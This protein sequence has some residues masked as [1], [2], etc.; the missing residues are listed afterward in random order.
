M[1]QKIIGLSALALGCAMT[2]A[3]WSA[4]P[5]GALLASTCTGCHGPNGSS[6][7]PATPIISGI[8]VETFVGEMK[9]F[10]TGER[11]STI[12][13]RL[14]K[15]YTDEEINAMAEYFSKQKF[16]R[17]PQP[18]D[19][20]KVKAGKA[21]ASENCES[22]HVDAGRKDED[23]SSILAGQ[24]LPYLQHAM[25]DFRAGTRNMPRKMKKRIDAILDANPN[26][27]DSVLQFYA[28]QNK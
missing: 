2:T 8:S 1:S 7:G 4:G 21:L 3:A 17:H 5:N 25:E 26:G 20:A 13:D 6:M 22:C 15:G 11:P 9:G 28:S 27:L 16:E 23:G 19:A 14:T 18:V 12:M 24:W 10:K